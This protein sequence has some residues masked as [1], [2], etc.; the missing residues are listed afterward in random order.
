M[1][2]NRPTWIQKIRRSSTPN[3]TKFQRTLSTR[4]LAYNLDTGRY[5]R[6]LKINRTYPPTCMNWRQG[7]RRLNSNFNRR[8]SSQAADAG[9][10]SGPLCPEDTSE[11]SPYMSAAVQSNREE[12]KVKG[13]PKGRR[14]NRAVNHDDMACSEQLAQKVR[15]LEVAQSAARER[16]NQLAAENSALN[17]RFERLKYL[18]QLHTAT[19]N[20]SARIGST[21]VAHTSPH[22]AV[23]VTSLRH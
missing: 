1:K 22:S 21:C 2:K 8:Q 23:A 11:R 6:S 3:A 4:R 17:K 19:T 20:Q 9:R 15:E 7:S 10:R 14:R 18:E 13:S 16:A 12:T 5:D